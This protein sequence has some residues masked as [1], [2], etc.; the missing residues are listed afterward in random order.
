MRDDI[1]LFTG[2]CEQ[3]PVKFVGI[4]V[5]DVEEIIKTALESGIDAEEVVH[6]HTI[7]SRDDNKAAAVILHTLHE[8]LQCL[9]TVL[10]AFSRLVDG[11]QRIGFINKENASL[12]LVAQTIDQF[13]C[14]ALILAHHLRPVNF[15]HVSAVEITYS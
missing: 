14:L 6:L 13:G 12:C 2:K 9:G 11:C 7:A 15:H 10:V 1:F 4:I 5:L 3:Y 8:G